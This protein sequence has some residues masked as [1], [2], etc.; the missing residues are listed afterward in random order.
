MACCDTHLLQCDNLWSANIMYEASQFR[1]PYL[2]SGD[3]SIT[4]YSCNAEFMVRFCT[5]M[6]EYSCKAPQCYRAAPILRV[7]EYHYVNMFLWHKNVINIASRVFLQCILVPRFPLPRFQ[8]PAGCALRVLSVCLRAFNS[9]RLYKD[10]ELAHGP[11][12]AMA[13][14]DIDM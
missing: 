12:K 5:L 1:K 7:V 4:A 6:S 2:K 13:S 3:S 9:F 8:R 11:W 14:V 10:L